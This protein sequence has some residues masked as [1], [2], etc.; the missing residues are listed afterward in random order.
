MTDDYRI[1]PEPPRQMRHYS[2]NVH[3]HLPE[4]RTNMTPMEQLLWGELRN[5]KLDGIKFR[6]QHPIGSFVLDFYA[7]EEFQLAVELDGD[8]HEL[9]ERQE[10]D[11]RRQTRLES[12]GITV[13]RI[14]NLEAA[15]NMDATLDKIR[16]EIAAKRR[17][18]PPFS[19]QREKGRG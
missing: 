6:R 5:R 3:R 2:P 1:S 14:T 11:A 10:A 9:P 18:R 13:L 7:P 15:Q 17:E 12:I 16:A 8:I 4:L 19:R